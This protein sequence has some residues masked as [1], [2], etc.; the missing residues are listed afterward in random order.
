LCSDTVETPA[1]S[2][3]FEG[4]VNWTAERLANALPFDVSVGNQCKQCEYYVDPDAALAGQR[5]GWAECMER[6]TGRPGLAAI[7]RADSVYGLFRF[8]RSQQLL[9][10]QRALISELDEKDIEAPEIGSVLLPAH[11]QRLQIAEAH[12]EVISPRILPSLYEALKS[13]RF[14]LHFVDFETARPAIPHH[15]GRT[16][17]DQILFQ[18]SHHRV[19]EDGRV[20]H[21]S[22]C[23]VAQPGV[24]PSAIVLGA[25]RDA[26]VSDEGTVVHWFAHERTVLGEVRKQILRD[27]ESTETGLPEFIDTLIG[28]TGNAG[29]LADLGRLVENTVFYPGTGGRSSIKRLL[30]AVLRHSPYLRARYGAPIYGTDTMPSLNFPAGWVWLQLRDGEV[31]DPYQLL[32]PLLAPGTVSEAVAVLDDEAEGDPSFIANGGA[33]MIA[34]GDLQRPNLPPGDRTRLRRELQR[35]CELDTLAM[36]MVYEALRD[37]E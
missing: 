18:F 7:R 10:E 33:A 26:L 17:N 37:E 15:R 1:G 20:T 31:I 25:L 6:H 36:V 11:R 4:F 28:P 5:N 30:P 35:Y 32:D 22:Q 27:R 14:P 34:Y 23:L 2:F 8:Q 12:G 19:T 16:P 13:W 24:A 3:T 21:A 29:R 9:D